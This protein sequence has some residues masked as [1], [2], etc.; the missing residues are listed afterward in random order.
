MPLTLE[1]MVAV[2]DRE[3][4]CEPF[5]RPVLTGLACESVWLTVFRFRSGRRR[6]CELRSAEANV[7]LGSAARLNRRGNDGDHRGVR[8]IRRKSG[9]ATPAIL[10]MAE[11]FRM[12]PGAPAAAG[13]D[14]LGRNVAARASSRPRGIA[15]RSPCR[16]APPVRCRRLRGRD[17][18]A[19]FSSSP[20]P[21]QARAR[22]RS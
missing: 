2:D 20:L 7:L 11:A 21:A 12:T 22:C 16:S 17:R 9:C 5:T 10:R 3:E 13:S 19:L 1:S 14:A 8:L 4:W 18:R 6:V 15:A